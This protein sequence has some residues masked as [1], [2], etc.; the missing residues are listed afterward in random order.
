MPFL[1]LEDVKDFDLVSFSPKWNVYHTFKSFCSQ[2]S[3]TPKIAYEVI[4]ALHMHFLAKENDGIG[5]CPYFYCEC[6]PSENIKIIP[7]EPENFGWS[8]SIVTKK[9]KALSPIIK[10][11]IKVFQSLS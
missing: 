1:T 3:V 11:L 5:I 6:L 9:D 4:D 2:R 8:I 10:G 7:F